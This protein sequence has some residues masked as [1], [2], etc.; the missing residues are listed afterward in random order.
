[1]ATLASITSKI[2][3]IISN[4]NKTKPIEENFFDTPYDIEDRKRQKILMKIWNTHLNSICNDI[5]V[6][7]KDL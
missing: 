5:Y 7:K 6:M 3:A 4:L 2:Q 1:M